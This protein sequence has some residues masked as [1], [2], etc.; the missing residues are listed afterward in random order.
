MIVRNVTLA[1]F[2]DICNRHD[3]AFQTSQINNDIQ[4]P[5]RTELISSYNVSDFNVMYNGFPDRDAVSKR[6]CRGKFMEKE[7]HRFYD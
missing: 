4:F 1:Y 6:F 3:V 7:N 2:N 5:I